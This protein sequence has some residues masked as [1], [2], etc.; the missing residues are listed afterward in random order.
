MKKT[1]TIHIGVFSLIVLFVAGAS[2]AGERVTVIEMADGHTVVFAMTEE[3]IIAA[4]A[5]RTEWDRRTA[6]KNENP[7][8]RVMTFEMGDGGLTITFPMTAKEIAAEDAANARREAL[9]TTFARKPKPN[10]I[11][12]ERPESGNYVVF[13]VADT[14]TTGRETV[15]TLKRVGN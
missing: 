7:K 6:V 4:D 11:K 13:P 10:V 2:V 5:A 14:E 12:I 3:E 9:R 15:E 1:A 8:P